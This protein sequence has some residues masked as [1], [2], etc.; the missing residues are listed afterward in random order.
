[1]HRGHRWRTGDDIDPSRINFF[2]RL[3]FVAPVG[4]QARRPAGHSQ[5]RT[6]SGKA[7]QVAE[8]GEMRNQKAA[9]AR[10]VYAAAQ[11]ADTS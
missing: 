8:I 3:R 5:G 6:R 4:K 11:L 10:A 9:K 1:L 2:R 7:C